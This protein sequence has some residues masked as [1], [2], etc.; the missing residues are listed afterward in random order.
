MF[1]Q[2]FRRTLNS[3]RNLASVKKCCGA[4]NRKEF[5][6]STTQATAEQCPESFFY[7]VIMAVDMT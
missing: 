3:G 6:L 1:L 7:F 2:Q 5:C 4:V